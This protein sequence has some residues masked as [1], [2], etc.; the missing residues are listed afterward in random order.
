MILIITMMFAIPANAAQQKK[1][2]KLNKKSVTMYVR[3]TQKLKVKV[4]GKVV[5]AKWSSSNKKVATVNAKGVITAK[6]PGRTTITARVNG[7]KRTCKV[8]VKWSTYSDAMYYVKGKWNGVSSEYFGTYFK[9]EGKYLRQYEDSGK[10]LKKDRIKG[11]SQ[12]GSNYVIYVGNGIKYMFKPGKTKPR[13]L[14]Y[15]WWD[16]DGGWMYSGSSSLMR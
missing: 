9:F 2:V 1:T 6:K 12:V 14:E 4:N 11:I 15:Y 16:P 3:H 8:R 7:V 10:L 13:S 5:K